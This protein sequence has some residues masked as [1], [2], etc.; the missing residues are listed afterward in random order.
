MLEF[1]F[2]YAHNRPSG[3]SSPRGG[4]YSQHR[5]CITE[6]NQSRDN[7]ANAQAQAE[8]EN[9]DTQSTQEFPYLS[10]DDIARSAATLRTTNAS[11]H[12][13]SFTVQ[14]YGRNSSATARNGKISPEDFPALCS[15]TLAVTSEVPNSQ[16]RK[17]NLSINRQ[18]NA[19]MRTSNVSIQLSQTST[20]LHSAFRDRKP[21]DE[22]QNS[23][24]KN[25]SQMPKWIPKKESSNFEDEFPKLEV[26]RTQP[27]NTTPINTSIT[28]TV[29]NQVSHPTSNAAELSKPILG[30]QFVVIKSK[31][32]KKKQNKGF[33]MDNKING[34]KE[35]MDQA[36]LNPYS[37]P[38]LNKKQSDDK[39]D[40]FKKSLLH[41][42]TSI[43]SHYVEDNPWEQKASFA[44]DDFPPLAPSEP[45]KRPPG[46]NAPKKR[47]PPGFNVNANTAFN[48]EPLNIS[49]SSIARQ[50]VIPKQV[51]MN[52]ISPDLQ[53]IPYYR[54]EDYIRRNDTITKRIEELLSDKKSLFNEFKV[55]S[56]KF[57]QNIISAA[58]YY[59]KCLEILGEKGFIEIFP[60]L[61]VLLPD[62]KKQQELLAVH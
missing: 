4:R 49:L 57:R 55:L 56:G 27:E 50:L 1:E 30:E 60:E 45:I 15:T 7:K 3:S 51:K 8:T 5:K 36:E 34:V 28:T 25:K 48:S 26:R 33:T 52:G 11:T 12:L 10:E 14:S 39:P 46:F 38:Y 6:E 29:I 41:S 23:S 37:F 31:S 9:L 44:P 20:P 2:T 32:K 40:P 53:E 21:S 18:N 24:D 16:G 17:I 62:V 22:V 61:V 54:P 58:E 47:T 13:N 19:P 42:D 59:P 43:R 35:E